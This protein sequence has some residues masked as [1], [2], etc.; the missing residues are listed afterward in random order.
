MTIEDGEP[1]FFACNEYITFGDQ[2]AAEQWRRRTTT[3]GF[4]QH[5]SADNMNWAAEGGNPGGHLWSE[6]WEGGSITEMLTPELAA[7]GYETDYG[8]ADGESLQFDY[9]NEAGI[10]FPGVRGCRGRERRA[11]LLHI[12]PIRLRMRRAGTP[13]GFRLSPRNG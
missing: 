8:F 9:R 6:D 1:L 13:S 7:N 2:D 3:D 11:V 12:S 4:T 5:H 10:E